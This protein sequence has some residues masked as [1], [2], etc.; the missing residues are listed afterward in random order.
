[1]DN[2]NIK[3]KSRGFTIVELL[4]VI[5]VIGI[6]AAITIVSYTGVTNK[7]NLSTNKANAS[8]IMKAVDA[9]FAENGY[10]PISTIANI[11]AGTVKAP[12]NFLLK[13]T[14]PTTGEA[15]KITYNPTTTSGAGFANYCIEYWDTVGNAK[16]TLASTGSLATCP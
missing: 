13:T 1:M 12:T 15:M 9:F 4:V 11:N 16:A 8:S 5:V 2:L 6:L 14:I 3:S 10:Y 7:A